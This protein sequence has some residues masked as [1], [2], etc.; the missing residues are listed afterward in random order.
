MKILQRPVLAS[1][2]FGLICGISFIPLNLLLN[3][4]FF[5]PSTICLTLW[6]FSAGYALLLAHWSKNKM[7]PILFPLLVLL[8]AAFLVKSVAAFCFLALAVISW[9][10]SGICFQH[11][12]GIKLVVE[13]LLCAA[14]S[15]MLAAF[16]PGSVVSWALSI[17]MF[18]LL[19]ALYF[20]VFD[21]Q[22]IAVKKKMIRS[23]IPLSG[24]AGRQRT[25]C[26]LMAFTIPNPDKPPP[27]I[28]RG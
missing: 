7:M 16:T 26:R 27:L 24:Q 12:F 1:I 18:F 14:A 5:W 11:H 8:M 13:M 3:S 4:V 22:I 20:V 9:I 2:L 17:W 23:S 10:R 6:L 25:S 21:N 15:A 28:K 19:Q